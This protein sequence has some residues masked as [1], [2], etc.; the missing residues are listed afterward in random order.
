MKDISNF[1]DQINHTISGVREKAPQAITITKD[2]DGHN[3][4]RTVDNFDY[5]GVLNMTRGQLDSVI[6][7]YESLR[8]DEK[9]ANKR[10]AELNESLTLNKDK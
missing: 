10:L 6:S 2:I 9:A 7:Q 3:V 4:M 1:L 8:A 5:E